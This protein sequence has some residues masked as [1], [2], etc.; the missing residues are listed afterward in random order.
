M[1]NVKLI[2][3]TPEPEMVV[4]AAA[5]N[6][7]S[8]AKADTILDGLTDESAAGFVSRLS[9]IGH[10]SPL[11][12]ASFTFAIDGVSRSLLAQIT[13]HRIA[14]F[15]VQSQRYVRQDGFNYVIPP[16]IDAIP[17]AKRLFQMAMETDQK[18]Y[19]QLTETL[20]NKQIPELV[21]S[22]IP[23]EQAR[24]QAEK[25]AIEDTRYVFPNACETSVVM[26]MNAREL[27]HFFRLRCCNRAQW[28]IR[29][30]ADKILALC[31][32]IAP[33]LF[34]NAGAPCEH[35]TCTEGKMSCGHPR[36]REANE[37]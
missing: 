35:G 18:I 27:Q 13:R 6:C 17:E 1:M 8:A 22:G 30:L 14:S 5:K 19:E 4:A 23:A 34:K 10:E 7:Y 29:E 32:E 25:R 24:R 3:H 37:V 16:E 36:R 21:T 26:T 31:T 28:E 33:N 20:M 11:E 12:H 9:D 2:S 15:S